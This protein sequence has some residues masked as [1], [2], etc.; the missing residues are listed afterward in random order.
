M[1]LNPSDI[2]DLGC[3]NGAVTDWLS[4]RGFRAIGLDS[5]E[6]GIKLAQQA[7]PHLEFKLADIMKP[8]PAGTVPKSDLVIAL[9][10]IEHLF[11]PRDLFN[12]AREVLKPGGHLLVSTPYHGYFKNIAIALTNHYDRHHDPLWDYGH[13]KFFSRRTLLGLSRE[14]GFDL[15]E[16]V[17]AGRLPLLAKS[18]LALFQVGPTGPNPGIS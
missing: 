15:K 18:M 17:T 11:L 3:G 7:Y 6:S 1:K 8:F 5:S 2:M 12:R 14:Q 13:I 4:R 10:V 16:F 9:D